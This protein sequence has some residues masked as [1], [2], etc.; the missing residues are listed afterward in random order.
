MDLIVPDWPD[1][2]AN[3]GVLSTTRRGGF[4]LAPFDDGSGAGGLDLGTHV[5]DSPLHVRENR[6]LLR[7]LLPA[8]P[9]WLMQVHGTAI[10]DAAGLSGVPE[11]DASFTT[12]KGVVCAIMTADC[13]PVLLCDQNGLVVAAAHAGWRGLCAGILEKTVARMRAAGADEITAWLGPAIGPEY[14][15]VGEDVRQ[16]FF[17]HDA[18]AAE[19]FKPIAAHGGK[20]L[21]DI[22]MLARTRLRHADVHRISGGGFCTAGDARR[23]Y[24]YRRDKVTGRMASLIWLNRETLFRDNI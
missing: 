17:A 8:E 21:A 18:R 7:A 5:M 16:A 10:V 14:F 4:S 15:E 3:V 6:S 23:F 9:A 1:L 19:A 20:Y 11:A 22:Y 24:S 13:L 12:A 2:P